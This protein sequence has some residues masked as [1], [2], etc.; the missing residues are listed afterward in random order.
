MKKI[1]SLSCDVYSVSHAGK[2]KIHLFNDWIE[3]TCFHSEEDL[4]KK[5]AVLIDSIPCDEKPPVE[6][7]PLT[8]DKVD[9]IQL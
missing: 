2:V 5:G 9:I 6:N 4:I 8:I 7:Q 3:S 1:Y